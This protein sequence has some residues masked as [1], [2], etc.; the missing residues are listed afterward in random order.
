MRT[1]E[2]SIVGD[3]R[4][5]VTSPGGGHVTV[6]LAEVRAWARQVGGDGLFWADVLELIESHEVVR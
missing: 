3:G 2:V 6:T 5:R 1:P 4:Y